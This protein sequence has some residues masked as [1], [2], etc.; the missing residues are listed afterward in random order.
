ML[1]KEAAMHIQHMQNALSQ[2]NLQLHNVITYITG[3]TGMRIIRDILAGQR[4]Q[5]ILAERK[6]SSL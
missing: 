1:T 4:D 6:R 5:K 2:M 3:D